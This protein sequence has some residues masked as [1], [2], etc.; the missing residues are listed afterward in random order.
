[1]S[2]ITKKQPIKQPLEIETIDGD[3]IESESSEIENLDEEERNF[4]PAEEATIPDV[5]LSVF[6][7]GDSARKW[8]HNPD[9]KGTF[10][11]L[12]AWFED[13]TPK[14][15]EHAIIYLYRS[16]PAILREPKYIDIISG[17]DQLTEDYIVKTHGGGKYLLVVVDSDYAKGGKRFEARLDISVVTADPF[18]NYKELDIGNRVNKTYVEQLKAK[19]ILDDDGEVMEKPRD[20]DM[21]GVTELIQA[22]QRTIETLLREVRNPKGE[23]ENSSALKQSMDMLGAA[24]NTAL[25]TTVKGNNK[26]DLDKL[27]QLMAIMKQNNP[28]PKN[29]NDVLVA[30][31]MKS[32]SDMMA[33]LLQM[34]MKKSEPTG[35][36]EKYKSMFEFFQ[37]I[38]GTGRGHKASTL[39]TVLEHAPSILNPIA[40][41][42]GNISSAR[43]GVPNP[44]PMSGIQVNHEN[45][46][47]EQ[48]AE[49]AQNTEDLDMAQVKMIVTQAGGPILNALRDGKPGDV[50]AEDIINLY[51]IN[52]FYSIQNIGKDRLLQ[53]MRQVPQFW[54]EVSLIQPQLN[55]FID[56]FMSWKPN[57]EEDEAINIPKEKVQ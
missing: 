1:M 18:I 8:P 52:L 13:F 57:E 41:I 30:T 44:V 38:S 47:H 25:Q 26:D 15:W 14:Q 11:D 20:K 21:Q 37:G 53:A 27:T 24:Y 39:E 29:N 33:M 31:L 43:T 45:I 42:I 4:I 28:E 46:Q 40:S 19:G 12:Q 10:E 23:V 16:W 2:R 9:K 51:G 17:P 54:N 7:R 22:Q 34:S 35:E 50:F 5:E 32:N 6:A 55:E 48:L 49:P 56:Q 36:L 3:F